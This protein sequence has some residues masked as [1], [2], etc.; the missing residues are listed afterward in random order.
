M[1]AAWHTRQRREIDG[2]AGADR[3][4]NP[5]EML[6]EPVRFRH[7]AQRELCASDACH[8]NRAVAQQP[9]QERF[10]QEHRLHVSE[11]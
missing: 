10:N 6:M 8:C 4:H 5:Q 9:A 11:Q 7:E 2:P 1:R 3:F